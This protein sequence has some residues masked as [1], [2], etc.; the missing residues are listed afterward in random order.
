MQASYT[1]VTCIS[2]RRRPHPESKNL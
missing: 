2:D 1:D